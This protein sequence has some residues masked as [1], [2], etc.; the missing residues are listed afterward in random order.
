MH[1]RCSHDGL[2]SSPL[3]SATKHFV[4]KPLSATVRT[5]TQKKANNRQSDGEVG[6]TENSQP[7]RSGSDGRL[8]GL[9]F[10]DSVILEIGSQ[11]FQ[12]MLSRQMVSYDQIAWITCRTQST[13]QEAAGPMSP[14][15]KSIKRGS[16]APAV[17]QQTPSSR[18]ASSLPWQPAQK[19]RAR[20]S[21]FRKETAGFALRVQ[22]RSADEGALAE[23]PRKRDK[24][25]H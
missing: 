4:K 16:R 6:L 20:P 14:I 21:K 15:M 9:T 18:A 7:G 24:P 17:P 25:F 19:E 10:V 1:P 13:S 11:D 23:I 12:V 22:K 2:I 3:D 5:H 8:N